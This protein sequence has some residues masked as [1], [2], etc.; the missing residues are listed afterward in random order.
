MEEIEQVIA[1]LD[2]VRQNLKITVSRQNNH[3]IERNGYIVN[4]H[5]RMGNVEIGTRRYPINTT[6]GVQA[7]RRTLRTVSTT[8]T[9]VTNNLL[10]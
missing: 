3:Q 1:T 6:D 5:K 9:R 10:T 8:P 7:C 2:D 4:S